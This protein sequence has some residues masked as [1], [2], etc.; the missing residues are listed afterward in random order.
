MIYMT[1]TKKIREKTQKHQ[2]QH[3]AHI[4]MFKDI[5]NKILIGVGNNLKL[6]TYCEKL[7]SQNRIENSQPA[8]CNRTSPGVTAEEVIQTKQ[9]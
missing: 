9:L 7:F 1:S 5:N 6:Q 4:E 3:K 2:K 8:E